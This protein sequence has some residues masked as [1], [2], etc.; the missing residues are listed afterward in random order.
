MAFR[1]ALIE[2]DNIY[3]DKMSIRGDNLN[4]EVL[5]S[6]EPSEAQLASLV[7]P[8][9]KFIQDRSV[10]LISLIPRLSVAH[11]YLPLIQKI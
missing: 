8:V 6:I 3:E 2:P 11:S 1:S 10:D 9:I 5:L 7:V 4:E